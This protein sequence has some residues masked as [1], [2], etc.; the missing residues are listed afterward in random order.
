[1]TSPTRL[2]LEGQLQQERYKKRELE[3][4][5][6]EKEKELAEEKY[7]LENNFVENKRKERMDRSYIDESMEYNSQAVKYTQ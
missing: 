4:L 3:R 7:M 5:Q 2:Q 1:M 6:K